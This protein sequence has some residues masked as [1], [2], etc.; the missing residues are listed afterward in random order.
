MSMAYI[1]FLFAITPLIW[2]FLPAPAGNFFLGQVTF[3]GGQV[4]SGQ[5]IFPRGQVTFVLKASLRC[6]KNKTQ[7]VFKW[8]IFT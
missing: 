6:A 4:T 2:P 7:S 3:F 5:V 1:G 8:L